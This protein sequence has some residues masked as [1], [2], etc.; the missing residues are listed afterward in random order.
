MEK[1]R[2]LFESSKNNLDKYNFYMGENNNIYYFFIKDRVAILSNSVGSC[3]DLNYM[4]AKITE[5]NLSNFLNYIFT[6]FT[7]YFFYYIMYLF[8]TL[9]RYTSY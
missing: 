1:C 7:F 3:D 9:F 8:Y 5:E 4:Q 2:E 6:F